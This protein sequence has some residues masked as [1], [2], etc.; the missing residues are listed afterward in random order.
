MINIIKKIV[1]A[2]AWTLIITVLL[3]FLAFAVYLV[4]FVFGSVGHH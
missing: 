1:L 2:L 4:F 3:G